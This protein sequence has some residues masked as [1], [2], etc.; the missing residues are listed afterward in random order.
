M[1][2][3]EPAIYAD[4]DECGEGDTFDDGDWERVARKLKKAGWTSGEGGRWYCPDCTAELAN[5]PKEPTP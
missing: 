1:S 4:C 5:A 3:S 2:I